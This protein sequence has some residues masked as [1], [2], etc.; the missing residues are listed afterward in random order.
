[1]LEE[2]LEHAVARARGSDRM[3]AVLFADLDGFKAVNDRFGHHSGDQLL[4]VVA[5]RLNGVLRPGDTL[6]RLSGDEFV[7]LCEDLADQPQAEAVAR[8]ISRVL[9]KPFVIDGHA[10][11]VTASVGVAFSGLGTE[12]P[13]ELLRDADQAM[14]EAKR[15]GGASTMSSTASSARPPMRVCRA[16]TTS[17]LGRVADSSGRSNAKS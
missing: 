4:K 5:S 13:K 12:I 2:R 6:A 3:A 16:G 15:G 17:W 9:A 1:L 7:V 8:R 14:Y 11:T 10:L